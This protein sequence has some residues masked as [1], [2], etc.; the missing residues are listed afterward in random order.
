MPVWISRLL[1]ELLISIAIQFGASLAATKMPPWLKEVAKVWIP[2][3]LLIEKLP[4][5]IKD[6]LAEI[7]KGI[8]AQ[9]ELRKGYKIAKR[10][11]LKKSREKA[12]KCVG[13]IGCSSE[14]KSA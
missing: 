5:P 13:I 11:A 3:L 1:L 14:L 4:Q 8:T 2:K 10:K 9:V 7:L 6:M 12:R